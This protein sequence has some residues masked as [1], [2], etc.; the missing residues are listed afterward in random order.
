[1]KMTTI[2]CEIEIDD[3]YDCDKEDSLEAIITSALVE[4]TH[5]QIKKKYESLFKERAKDIALESVWQIDK[6]LR[7][8]IN[9]DIVITDR[10]G[11]PTFIGSVED[12]IKKTIDEKLLKPVDADGNI[13]RNSCS[14]K[15]NTWI[16]WYIEKRITN[17]LSRL[18]NKISSITI[19]ANRMI[20]K[21]IEEFK[22]TGLNELIL[23]RLQVAGL[24]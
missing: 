13:L 7:N 10:W 9:E 8:L 18:D 3:I 16:E 14:T 15:E 19:T 23:K 4:A 5:K 20:T 21:Q 2:K 1:M 17:Y 22:N 12:Y 11:K 6:K 24:K